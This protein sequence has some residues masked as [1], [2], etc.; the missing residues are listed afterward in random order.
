MAEKSK[1]GRPEVLWPLFSAVTALDGIGP[2]TAQ[3]LEPFDIKR[4]RDILFTLPLAGIDRRHRGSILDVVAPS[5]VTV[6]VEI[7]GHQ[8]AAA[9]GRPARVTVRDEQTTFQL[10]FFHA[11]QK[12]LNAQLPIGEKRVISGKIETF[13][14]TAQMVHPD[15][16]VPLREAQ[17]I[18]SFE[19]VYPLHGGISQKLM[20]RATRAA[21][22]L[23]PDLPE[24]IDPELAKRKGWPDWQTALNHSHAPTG[25]DALGAED[26]ARARLAYDELFA[27]QLTLALARAG[28]RRGKGRVSKG[29]GDLR[30]KVM[31]NLP[32][33]PTGAQRR[34]VDEIV[35]D[36]AQPHR[37]NRLLQ[38]DVG[39]GKTLVALMA[40]LNAVEAGG[41]AVMMAPTEILARQHLA[42][43]RALTEAAGIRV[44]CLTGRDKGP[45]RQAM[46]AALEN[47]E[48]SILIGTHAVFQPDVIFN[49]LR[50]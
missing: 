13:D 41:Q 10:V 44:E 31:K 33:A 17:K 40:M 47:G 5:V 6:E 8:P 45:D 9:K 43:L 23:M 26:P 2:K 18:P 36:M 24:W 4:P 27:H 49:D 19:P 38:G 15:H 14:G 39:S 34:T 35:T 11:H 28:A 20:W 22:A 3:L 29:N 30:R 25:M 37:M 12:W 16:I 7:L 46:L 1:T 32:Y 42:G 50:L 48:I 21:L